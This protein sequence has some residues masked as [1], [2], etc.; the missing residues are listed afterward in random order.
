MSIIQIIILA[1]VQGLAELLP[2]SSSAHVVVVSK[3]M[4]LDPAAPA[5]TFLIVMLH[6]GTMLAVIAYFWRA[7]KKT[8]FASAAIFKKQAIYLIF[9]TLLTGIIGG[10]LTFGIEHLANKLGYVAK[11]EAGHLKKAEIEML[12]G[13]L[14]LV[15]VALAA[16]GI[17][18]IAAGLSKKS[19]GSRE[20]GMKEAGWMG[21]GAG[22]VLA[23]SRFFKVGCHDLDGIAVGIAEIASGGILLCARGA[24]HPRG[25]RAGNVAF[26]ET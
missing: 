15:S 11:D 16:A 4:G 19:N 13:N 3:L 22:P 23:I 17:L 2:V 26:G 1:I 25:H 7:W 21:G 12:F 18:I 8:F 5:M 10:G 14:E 24:H 6:T 20:V 9:A